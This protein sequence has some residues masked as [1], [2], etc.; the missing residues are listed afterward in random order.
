MVLAWDSA[1]NRLWT[2]APSAWNDGTKLATM[3]AKPE[4]LQTPKASKKKTATRVTKKA[5]AAAKKAAT[6]TKRA[7][8]AAARVT[9]VA[10]KKAGTPKTPATT[11]PAKTTS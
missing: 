4:T 11:N 10:A 7:A 9:A 8:R 1:F 5:A 6:A 3:Y 2:L